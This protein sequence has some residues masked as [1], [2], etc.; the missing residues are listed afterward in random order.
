M[1]KWKMRKKK[2]KKMMVWME[3]MGGGK[4]GID[5]RVV[6]LPISGR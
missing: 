1:M 3:E 2:M 5:R 4:V 6:N